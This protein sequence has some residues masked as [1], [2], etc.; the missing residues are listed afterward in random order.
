MS[1]K[2]RVALSFFKEKKLP[3][4]LSKEGTVIFFSCLHCCKEAEMLTETTQWECSHCSNEGN[5][6]A[7]IQIPNKEKVKETSFFNP[8]QTQKDIL[9]KLN[10]LEDA[11]AA[12]IIQEK[13]K[14]LVA[15]YEKKLKK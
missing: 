11:E 13:I 15:Y 2:K 1:S 6:L 9:K 5:L 3:Y 4:R 7:L 12:V 14:N 10:E 8:I